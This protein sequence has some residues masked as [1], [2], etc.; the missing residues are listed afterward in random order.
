MMQKRMYRLWDKGGRIMSTYGARGTNI[1][2]PLSNTDGRTTWMSFP[3][4]YAVQQGCPND[5][6]DDFYGGLGILF[7]Q[8][9]KGEIHMLTMDTN[10]AIGIEE[11][12][13]D[14][15]V[16]GSNGKNHVNKA[17]EFLRSWL[18]QR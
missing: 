9:L 3:H 1:R 2:F 6:R 17:G 7:D 18:A 16:C 15:P 4:G 10:A 11:E 5:E 13:V 14:Q 12:R 8:G